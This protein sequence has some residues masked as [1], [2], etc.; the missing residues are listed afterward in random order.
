M[1][2]MLISLIVPALTIL[3]L[4]AASFSMVAARVPNGEQYFDMGA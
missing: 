4:G 2:G 1:H 3:V